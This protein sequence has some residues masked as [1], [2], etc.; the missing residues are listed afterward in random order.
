[1]AQEPRLARYEIALIKAMLANKDMPK[2]RIQA[3]FTRPDR[4]GCPICKIREDGCRLRECGRRLPRL[5]RE[6]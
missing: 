5:R 6:R 1:M 4:K 3:Y 2:D